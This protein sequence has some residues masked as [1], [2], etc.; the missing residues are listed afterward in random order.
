MCVYQAALSILPSTLMEKWEALTSF[1]V[2]RIAVFMPGTTYA[3]AGCPLVF[4][5]GSYWRAGGGAGLCR[6]LRILKAHL[7]RCT[8]I[9]GPL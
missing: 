1:S 6:A 8:G 5:Y 9:E 7:E 4:C 3:S 2:L